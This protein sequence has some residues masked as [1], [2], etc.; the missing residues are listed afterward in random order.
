[1]ARADVREATRPAPWGAR[2]AADV[3]AQCVTCDR[4]CFRV[5]DPPFPSAVASAAT[6]VA[7]CTAVAPRGGVPAARRAGCGGPAAGRGGGLRRGDTPRRVRGGTRTKPLRAALPPDA[8]APSTTPFSEL[9]AVLRGR[10]PAATDEELAWLDAP[11]PAT[12]GVASPT[13]HG[14]AP[15]AAPAGLRH[16]LP[17]GARCEAKDAAGEWWPVRVLSAAADG[18]YR[19]AEAPAGTDPGHTPGKRFPGHVAAGSCGCTVLVDGVEEEWGAV[20]HANT[21]PEAE[22]GA[23]QAARRDAGGPP[24][25]RICPR[26]RELAAAGARRGDEGAGERLGRQGREAE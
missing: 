26:S 22:Y 24:T 17:F 12:A 25:P 14:G 15:A 11:P 6:A 18:T 19:C 8:A 23:R 16:P 7:P 2:R 20:H 13:Q 1:M 4:E 9:R 10:L 5:T 3:S 21:R